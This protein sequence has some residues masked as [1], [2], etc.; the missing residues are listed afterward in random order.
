MGVRYSYSFKSQTTA[1]IADTTSLTNAA[2]PGVIQGGTSTQRCNVI[3]IYMGGEV[4]TSAANQNM[5]L[6]RDSTVAGATVSLTTGTTNATALTL[7]DGSGTAPGTVPICGNTTSGTTPQRSSTSKL[8]NLSFNAYGGIVRWVS[9]QGEEPSLVGNTA[10]LGEL[11][12]SASSGTT[13]GVI[14]GHIL[15]EVA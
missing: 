15:F 3:E 13:A 1:A 9:R 10:S 5:I 2:Y 12:L 11:S 8:L 14:G 6:A 7:L 4:N